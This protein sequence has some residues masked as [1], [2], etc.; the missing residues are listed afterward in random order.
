MRRLAVVWLLAAVATAEAPIPLRD[1]KPRFTR[2]KER[3][4][5]SRTP[6][7]TGLLVRGKPRRGLSSRAPFRFGFDIDGNFERLKVSVAVLD[8]VKEPV[9][10][11]VIGDGQP[12]ASTPP[13]FA[14]AK[15]LA[16]DVGLSGVI[17]LEFV[18]EGG[19]G[20]AR[21]AWID[22]RLWGAKG[23]DLGR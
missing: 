8:G 6:Q 22:G 21:G 23:R 20:G 19:G 11:R 14:G 15:P 10:F 12:L 9:V 5:R 1:L 18:A 2:G 13:L 17:L 7:N 4:L 16:I 3:L